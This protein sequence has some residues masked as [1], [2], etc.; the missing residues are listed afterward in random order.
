MSVLESNN[1]SVLIPP[2]LIYI[3]EKKKDVYVCLK[4]I[5]MFS[6]NFMQHPAPCFFCRFYSYVLNIQNKFPM[7]IDI[8]M[9]LCSIG[10]LF[11][12]ESHGG[13]YKTACYTECHG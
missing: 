4:I 2:T 5:L 9:L 13:F 3:S 12:S 10:L 6:T 11:A 7:S 1:L 8:G